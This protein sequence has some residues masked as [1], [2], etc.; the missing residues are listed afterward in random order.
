MSF[1]GVKMKTVLGR[2]E[3][4]GADVRSRGTALL[5]GVL[6]GTSSR[7]FVVSERTIYFMDYQK[8]IT[9]GKLDEGD[10]N[11]PEAIKHYSEAARFARKLGFTDASRE[12]E[13]RA[14]CLIGKL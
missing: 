13:G 9:L 1:V 4:T 3:Q 8:H 10:K 12:Y 2:G 5:R 11:Y 14:E 6:D 7:P